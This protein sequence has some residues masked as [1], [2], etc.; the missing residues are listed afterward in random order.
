MYIAGIVSRANP[1]KSQIGFRTETITL[2]PRDNKVICSF[3]ENYPNHNKILG[4]VD[5]GTRNTQ[6]NTIEMYVH[7]TSDGY[8]ISYDVI[9]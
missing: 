9:L 5:G 6:V 7:K 4:N 8:S 1:D 3:G 2:T